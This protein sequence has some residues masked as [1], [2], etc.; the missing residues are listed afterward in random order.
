MVLILYRFQQTDARSMLTAMTIQVPWAQPCIPI[1]SWVL[2]AH[3]TNVDI[4]TVLKELIQKIQDS[5]DR[6]VNIQHIMVS[7]FRYNM[8]GLYTETVFHL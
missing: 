4:E 2:A 7:I 8:H 1:G 3:Q 6:V 5:Y